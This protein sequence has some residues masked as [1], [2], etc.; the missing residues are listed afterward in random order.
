MSTARSALS[1]P[2]LIRHGLDWSG[3]STRLPYFLVAVTATALTVLIPVTQNFSG[4]NTAVFLALTA[5]FPVWLGHTRRRLRDLG[6]SGWWM[7]LAI[8]PVMSLVMIIY[9]SIKPGDEFDGPDDPGYSRLAFAAALICG[10]AMLSR[11]FWAPYWIPSSSM[12]PALLPG[13]F[14]AVVPVT[15]PERGDIMVYRDLEA[16]REFIK[17]LIGLP[18]DRVQIIEGRAYLNDA[19]LPERA[20]GAFDTQTGLV[21]GADGLIIGPDLYFLIKDNRNGAAPGLIGAN[22]DGGG[23][24]TRKDLTGRAAVVLFS[25]AGNSLLHVWAW[26]RDRFFRRIE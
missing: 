14:I 13:D 8:L 9:L 7:W 24:V 25:S 2:M 3:R 16:G 26:R 19:L 10:A 23:L 17:R 15:E 1:P 4:A 22:W 20:A 6:W 5:L 12:Q 18:G 21:S 11:A